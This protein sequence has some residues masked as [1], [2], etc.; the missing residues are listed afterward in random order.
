MIAKTIVS[1]L[2]ALAFSSC[3]SALLAQSQ[4]TGRIS[5][6]VQDQNGAAIAR[7]E[8]TA[9]NL[10]TE[11]ERKVVTDSEGNYSVLLLPPGLYRVSIRATGFKRAFI[12]NVPVIITQT[13]VE[14]AKLEVG[15]LKESVTINTAP[16]LIQRDGPQLGRVVDSRAVS[17]LPLATRNFTQILGLSPGTSTELPDN[18]AVGRN[19]QMISVNGA[20]ATQNNYEINGVD[21]NNIRN[22]NAVRVAVP[23]PETI[24]EFKVQTS[25][26]DVT[27][28]RS[29]GGNIQAITR[30]GAND[31]HG[32][33]YE[34]FLNDALT[35]NNPFLKAAGVKRPVLKR[36]IF[37]GLLGGR[38]KRDKAFF[39]ISYQGTRE[40]NVASDNSLSSSVLIAQGLTNVRSEQILKQTFNVPSVSPIAL[41]L[42]NAKLPNGQFLIHTPQADGRYSGS[43]PS[44][45]QED[46]FNTNF[47][48]RIN[49]QNWLTAKFFFS[50]APQTL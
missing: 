46:Q 41:A 7:A 6:T 38:L 21:A 11:D 39:F 15:E 5:G 19:S 4:T 30:S 2:L 20:R 3:P 36:N 1:L 10:A 47:D 50:N 24:Q 49:Q 34:Y 23:A 29:G 18:T 43:V 17:E 8:V 13:T 33:A 48:W 12:E 44:R 9:I 40:R 14:E 31:F 32:A 28:G 16:S 26:Y 22:N 37:G 45:Y 35:A 27:F 42:L 25:L